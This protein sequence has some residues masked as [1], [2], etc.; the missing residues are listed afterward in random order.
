MVLERD[1]GKKVNCSSLFVKAFLL[2]EITSIV[3][4]LNH[5]RLKRNADILLRDRL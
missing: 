4:Q 1:A 3:E 5:E 2:K